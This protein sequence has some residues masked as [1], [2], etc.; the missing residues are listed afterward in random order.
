MIAAISFLS[1]G[2]LSP[3]ASSFLF[4][5]I[6]SYGNIS[7]F[8]NIAFR[9]SFSSTRSFNSFVAKDSVLFCYLAVLVNHLL[10]AKDAFL[11]GNLLIHL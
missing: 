8:A 11:L 10:W 2:L 6:N 5:S 7:S 9:Y 3:K 4:A 1:S